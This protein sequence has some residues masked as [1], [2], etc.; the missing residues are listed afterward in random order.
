MPTLIRCAI[1]EASHADG[2]VM[3]YTNAP[4]AE[5]QAAQVIFGALGAQGR[6]PVSA[7]DIFS[8]GF[9]L[10]TEV[11]NRLGY[12]LPGEVDI[13]REELEKI[14]LLVREA[15]AKRATPGC[16]LLIARHGK[17]VWDKTYGYQTYARAQ[18]VR[19]DDRFMTSLPL[20]K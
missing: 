17:V 16:Q 11:L 2:F 19:S 20:P 8:E 12:G 3:A 5:S 4:S 13:D 6:L 1:S 15:I 14:D 10:D 18:A 9:G 7:S